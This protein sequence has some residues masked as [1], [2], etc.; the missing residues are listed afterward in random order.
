MVFIDFVNECL[1]PPNLLATFLL[2][3]VI[4]YWLLVIVG[5]LGM[6][7]FDIHLDVDADVGVDGDPGFDVDSETGVDLDGGSG[8]SFGVEALKFFHL[9]EI[10][11]MVVVSFFVGSFWFVSYTANHYLNPETSFIVSMYWLGPNLLISLIMLKAMTMPL[12]RLF[13]FKDQVE[14]TRQQL[15]HQLAIVKT[16]EV[17]EKFGEVEINREGPPLALT[18]RAGK[19]DHFS[20]GDVVR[21]AEY[22]KLNDTYLVVKAN[23]ETD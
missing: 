23:R 13:R 19:G 14:T 5:F 4:V 21:I 11:L 15:I 22:N 20:K 6:E 12:S 1:Q 8:A 18:A 7:A 10:P 3:L 17:T 16:S 2:L 9:G